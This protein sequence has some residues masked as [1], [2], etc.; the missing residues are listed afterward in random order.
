MKASY[1]TLTECRYMSEENDEDNKTGRISINHLTVN[2]SCLK[3]TMK[4]NTE[5]KSCMT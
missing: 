1:G 3:I 5:V 2:V 4:I